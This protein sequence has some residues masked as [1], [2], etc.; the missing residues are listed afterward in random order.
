LS[1]AP[2]ALAAGPA[3]GGLLACALLLACA[4]AARAQAPL[5]ADGPHL[6]DREGAVVILRGMNVATDAKLPPFRPV[7]DPALLDALPRWGVNVVR[8]LFT[9]EAFE[10]ERERYDESYL[11][12][13]ARTIEACHAR[14]AWVILDLH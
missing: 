13:I 12:Y 1:V 14:G 8:L 9:W 2:R 5:R 11:D 3:A 6:R 7:D 10:P 4:S